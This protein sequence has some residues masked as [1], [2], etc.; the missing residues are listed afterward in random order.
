MGKSTGLIVRRAVLAEAGVASGTMLDLI[1]ENG[2]SRR[3]DAGAERSDNN[4]GWAEA[5]ERELVGRE[6]L[7]VIILSNYGS[8]SSSVIMRPVG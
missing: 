8:V 3:P 2:R 4:A 7:L 5:A 6:T 1:V